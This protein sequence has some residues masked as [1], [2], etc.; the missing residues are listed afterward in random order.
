MDSKQAVQLAK[1][2]I[3]D[4]FAEEGARNI[5]LEELEYQEEPGIW[6]VTVGFSRP[7]EMQRNALTDI[8]GQTQVQRSY[9]IV[10]LSDQDGQI[11]S[12]KSHPVSA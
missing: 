1:R 5:G 11:I 8:T 10:R 9:K 4:L 3:Q 7:W 6:L 12:V 2:H